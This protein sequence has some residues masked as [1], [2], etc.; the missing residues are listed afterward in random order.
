MPQRKQTGIFRMWDK[1]EKCS[2]LDKS[3]PWRVG[4]GER[5]DK[6]W[7]LLQILKKKTTKITNTNTM[8]SS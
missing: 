5:A 6:K 8:H 3:M 7:E 2:G 4:G 1:Q